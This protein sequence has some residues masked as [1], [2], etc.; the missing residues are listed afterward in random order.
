MRLPIL[1]VNLN[2]RR[3][4]SFALVAFIL[5]G[6]LGG[7]LWN[8]GGVYIPNSDLEQ[9][10]GNMKH[11]TSYDELRAYITEYGSGYGGVIRVT[12][13][14][15]TPNFK[16]DMPVSADGSQ[17]IPSSES[18]GMNIDF[19]KTNVQVEGVDEADVVKTDGEYIYYAKDNQVIVIRAYPAEESG[20]IS[21]IK[22]DYPV[23]NIYVKGNKLVVFSAEKYIY[24]DYTL[25]KPENEGPQTTLSIFDVSDKFDPKK[26]REFGM[27]GTYFNSRLID[28]Y[29]YYIIT[30]PAYV[31]D[32][33]VF[34]PGIR[35][36]NTW[37]KV[38][39]EQIWYPNNTRGWLQYYTVA[40]IDVE[41]TDAQLHSEIFLL[42]SGSTI[43]ASPTNIYLTSQ[44]WQC[45]TTIT[46]IGVDNGDIT[47]KANG[48][49]PGYILNQFSM[50][51]Y[52]GY[53]RVATTDHDR[54]TGLSG[55]NLYILN[56]DLTIVGSLEDLA[57]GEDIYSARFMGNRCYL[58]TFKKIDPLF[59]IDLSDH[60]APKVLGK[61]KIPGYSDY[62]HPYDENTLIGIGKETVESEEGDFAWYQGVKISLFDVSDVN[63]PKELSKIEIGDRGTE[64]PALYDHH[65]FLFSKSRNLLVIP[66]LEAKINE[67]VFAGS[68]PDNFYGE[69]SYQ[70]A[71]VFDISRDGVELR[72]IVTHLDDNVDLI[73][74]G[75]WFHSEYQIERSLFIEEN[76]Y[77]LSQGM[78]KINNLNTL[79]EL[80]A[81]DL[82]E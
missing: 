13:R 70:G 9:A 54:K 78:I 46:K 64:S 72:G 3:L 75:F 23:S 51:E 53:F 45:N 60:E 4:T 25:E 31:H 1:Q 76:L 39:V 21:R 55:N 57:P 14:G 8:L 41:D 37:R 35:E 15:F 50:D 32:E 63:N 33:E 71:Y 34:L 82:G 7:V 44:G 22:M 58:V 5:G 12:G 56:S 28:N 43:Y 24:Y 48:T 26:V 49:I 79:S 73:K 17:I 66:I 29:L 61:L 6:A 65:A 81:I 20:V 62:L 77:T 16:N 11:F 40:S 80:S 18:S 69:F 27:E 74:S 42:D 38:E 30:N 2:T 10:F 59:T 19:S 68:A 67:D 47:F 36:N 52:N